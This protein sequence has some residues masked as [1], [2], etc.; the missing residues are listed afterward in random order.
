MLRRPVLKIVVCLLTGSSLAW[1]Q[2]AAP[3]ISPNGIVNAADY[4][5]AIAPGALIAVFGDSLASKTSTA[6]N[7]PLPTMLDGSSVEVNGQAI[8]LFFVSTQQINAQMPFGVVGQVQVRVRTAAGLSAGVTVAVAATAPRLFTK[9]MDGKGEPI[10]V[11]SADWSSVSAASPA[12]PGEYLLLFLTGLGAVSPAIPAGQAGGDNGKN[13]P[14]NQ[15]PAGA[16][17]ITMGDRPAPVLF[18]GLAPGW[19]G[20][21]QVNFQAPADMP[22][23]TIAVT[24]STKDGSSQAGVMAAAKGAPALTAD[25]GGGIIMDFVQIAPGQFMMGCSTGDTLCGAEEKPQ[26]P[27]QLTKGFQ[28][29]KFE[30]TQAQWQAVMGNNPSSWRFGSTDLPVEDVSLYDIEVFLQK[31]DARGDGYSYRLPTEAEWEYAARA[32]TTGPTYG[33]LDDIAWHSGNSGSKTH[34]VGQKQPNAWGLYDMLGNVWELVQDW[35][36]YSYDSSSLAVDPTGWTI[37]AFKSS[38]GGS[39]SS[40]PRMSTRLSQY[41]SSRLSNAGFRCVRDSYA[42][43]VALNDLKISASST[44]SSEVVIGT[45]TLNTAA[46][47]EGIAVALESANTAAATVPVS[48]AIMGGQ[49][50][51]TFNVW[52]KIVTASQQT[53]ITA[54]LGRD[55]KMATLT[56]TPAGNSAGTFVADLGGGLRMDFVPIKPGDFVMGCSPMDPY[57]GRDEKP[58]HPVRLTK[59]LQMGR[60]VVTQAQWQAIMGGNP[61]YPTGEDLPVEQVSWNDTQTFLS[62]MNARN[63]GYRYRLPTEAEWEYAARAGTTGPTYGDLYRIAWSIYDSNGRTHPV[64]QKTPNAWGLYDMLGNVYEWV[65]DRYDGTYDSSSLA[66]DPSGSSSGDDRVLRSYGWAGDGTILRASYRWHWGPGMRGALFGF[67]CVRE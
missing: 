54:K 3:A 66:V 46:P 23:G 28:M 62:K 15:L 5:P 13:G 55:T 36:S 11:H 20:L 38:R 34:P 6:T 39:Y 16:L 21:Y 18:A 60:F 57:C 56:V 63:D 65:Q 47:T 41:P 59:S 17:T 8:P 1:A 33:N 27:V 53:V 4:T 22:S 10:L 40:Y 2:S 30:V 61:S 52:L 45:L 58:A 64:G 35:T 32:G 25:M 9:T 44:A 37:G 14:L 19:V 50:S 26:H 31:M 7:T 12:R 51:A 42:G 67:R 24:A 49:T 29:G 48:V 43:T